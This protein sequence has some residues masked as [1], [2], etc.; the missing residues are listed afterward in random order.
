MRSALRHDTTG[1]AVRWRG[2]RRPL[3]IA[4]GLGIVAF[5]AWQAVVS[6]DGAEQDAMRGMADSLAVRT[7]LSAG[8]WH[9]AWPADQAVASYRVRYFA[10]DGRLLFTRQ[11]TDTS[12]DVSVDSLLA[13]GLG[14]SLFLD[15]QGLDL[16]QRPVTRSPLLPLTAP[17][18]RP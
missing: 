12:L 16:L 7:E 9:A 8:V 2:W 1:S 3:A 14:A 11:V 13:L 4:A 5:G 10:A 18:E 15:V 17:V 6:R